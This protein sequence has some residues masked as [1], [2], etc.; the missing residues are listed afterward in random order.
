VPPVLVFDP[1]N[2]S[3][4]AGQQVFQSIGC[5]NC[6]APVLPGPG[7]RGPLY[8]FSDLLLHDMGPALADQMQQASALGNEWRTMPLWG[9][10]ERGRFLHDGRALTLAD[11]IAAHG[12]QAQHARDLFVA[13]SPPDMLALLEFLNGI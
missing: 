10:S 5:A 2:V 7:A 4:S 8:L 11:A 3:P 9:V 13:L 12:G 6:H 1:T